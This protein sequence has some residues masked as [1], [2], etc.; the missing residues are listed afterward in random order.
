MIKQK[1]RQYES[2]TNQ[3]NYHPPEYPAAFPPHVPSF[4]VCII[5]Q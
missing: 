4:I 1:K 2:K 5:R 3:H